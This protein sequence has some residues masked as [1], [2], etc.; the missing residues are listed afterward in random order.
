MLNLI[1]FG[2]P[3][4]G[5]GT[6]SERL[7]ERYNLVHL[8]TGDILRSE[9]NGNSVLGLEAKEFIDKGELV[10]D[11][12]GIEMIDSIIDNNIYSKGFIFDGFPRT[13]IQAIA[14]DKLMNGKDLS[15]DMLFALDV[16]HKIL[17]ERILGRSRK[18]GR[19]D[20]SDV[21][22]IENRIKVYHEQT[23]PLVNYYDKQGKYQLIVGEGSIEEIFSK[24][25]NIIDLKL[26]K[27]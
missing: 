11:N 19:S 4:S 10:P 16:E 8:S 17:I 14:L 25:C 6:Q 12:I 1:L 2:P 24:I 20:D 13:T 22:I 23:S 18:S 27:N 5:K 9:I 3:G 15:I 26:T 21:S 7:I